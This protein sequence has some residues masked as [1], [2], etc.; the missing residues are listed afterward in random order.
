MPCDAANIEGIKRKYK[1][2]GI[3]GRLWSQTLK[4]CLISS[5]RTLKLCSRTESTCNTGLGGKNG[6]VRGKTIKR[7]GLRKDLGSGIASTEIFK[8]CL[9]A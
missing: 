1:G 5:R 2:T 4:N 6:G 8:F 3:K 7:R 9:K